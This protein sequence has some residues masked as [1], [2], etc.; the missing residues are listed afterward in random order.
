MELLLFKV[1]ILASSL[2]K[3]IYTRNTFCSPQSW[4]FTGRTDGE[5]EAPILWPLD[6]KSWLNGKDPDPG[7]DWRH[8]E[9]G[10][11]G[12]EMVGW[13][14]WP[15][16]HEFEQTL[17]DSE[18]QG[19]KPG[20]L[21]SM[22]SQRV[23]HDLESEQQQE[24]KKQEGVQLDLYSYLIWDVIAYRCAKTQSTTSISLSEI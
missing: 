8:E 2:R 6:A 5:A 23:G 16:G 17:R 10:M 19:K 18:G 22:G 13:H 3:Y 4:I 21:Q 12:D 11:T 14:H 24:P 15:N 1:N 20:V 9:K 7:K